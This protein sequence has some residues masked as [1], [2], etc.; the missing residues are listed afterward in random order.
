MYNSTLS[1]TSALD[2]VGGQ[3]H[4]PANLPPGKTRYPL[5]RR[6]SGPQGRPGQVRKISPPPGF[7]PRTVQPVASFVC[8]GSSL[9][10][11]TVLSARQ[12]H[13]VSIMK[14]SQ[15][16][17]QREVRVRH[18]DSCVEHIIVLCGQGAESFNV[19][20][21][22]RC[23]NQEPLNDYVICFNLHVKVFP[24]PSRRNAQL[25]LSAFIFFPL[26]SLLW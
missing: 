14:T 23:S 24:K 20:A 22:G 12:T 1:L 9:N 8:K 11:L 3:R 16:V 18:F 21:C 25:S 5:Y 2:G 13:S 26:Y 7:D 4:S 15:L 17:L 10:K 19:G 6:L